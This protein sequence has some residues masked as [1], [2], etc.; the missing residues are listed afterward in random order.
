MASFGVT[1]LTAVVLYYANRNAKPKAAKETEKGN[2]EPNRPLAFWGEDPVC[3][4]PVTAIQA[5]GF[6]VTDESW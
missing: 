5:A 3:A 4:H 6:A 2:G 1:K